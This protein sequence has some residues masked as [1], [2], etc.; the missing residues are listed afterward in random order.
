MVFLSFIPLLGAGRA[1]DW[2]WQCHKP[3]GGDAL[4][5]ILFAR[6]A[7][8]STWFSK[9]ACAK[10]RYEL[11]HAEPQGVLQHRESAFPFAVFVGKP[12]PAPPAREGPRRENS[13][14]GD[15]RRE[16]IRG[17]FWTYGSK[18]AVLPASPVRR[19]NGVGTGILFGRFTPLRSPLP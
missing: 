16:V 15:M 11:A 17:G 1:S 7:R 18:P 3:D 8:A 19:R 10:C 4:I 9:Y 13:S 5:L 14:F 6:I 2:R 12:T